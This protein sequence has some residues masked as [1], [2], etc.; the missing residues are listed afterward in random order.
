[1][2]KDIGGSKNGQK[3]AKSYLLANAEGAVW[4][5]VPSREG[6]SKVTPDIVEEFI[7][8]IL[9]H[10]DIVE[11]PIAMDSI[12][13]WNT[14]HV[15]KNKTKPNTSISNHSQHHDNTNEIR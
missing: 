8:W 6:Y 9:E 5:S 4:S 3:P 1:V 15:C 14:E 12:L 7:K 10:P 11:S 13:V 2:Q